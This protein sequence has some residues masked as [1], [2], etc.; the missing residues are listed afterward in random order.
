MAIRMRFVP[1]SENS[2]VDDDIKYSQY[3][4]KP[5]NLKN[6]EVFFIYKEC[7]H[8]DVAQLVEH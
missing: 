3:T 8:V 4:L 6:S 1:G 2:K 5:L 7:K